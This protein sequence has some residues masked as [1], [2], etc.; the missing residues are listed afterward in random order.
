VNP[1]N[2]LICA[3]FWVLWQNIPMT[4]APGIMYLP[5]S[6]IPDKLTKM[7][8]GLLGT[9]WVVRMKSPDIVVGGQIRRIFMD[10]ART[11]LLSLEPLSEVVSASLAQQRFNMIFTPGKDSRRIVTDAPALALEVGQ[12]SS[13]LPPL[14]GLN[15][16]L[17]QL[18]TAKGAANQKRQH[19][20]VA[21]AFQATPQLG[22]VDRDS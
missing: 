20:V 1:T 12:D 10:N 18:I 21:L 17:G 14:D 4:P 7:D 16:K 11:P 13:P 3:F 22:R 15:L 19:D 8:N 5:A 9:S 2:G 6:Q